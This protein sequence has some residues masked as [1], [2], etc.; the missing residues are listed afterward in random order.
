MLSAMVAAMASKNAFFITVE[1]GSVFQKLII[2][3]RLLIYK[4]ILTL[5]GYKDFV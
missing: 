1:I 2:D 4:K 5:V 3:K